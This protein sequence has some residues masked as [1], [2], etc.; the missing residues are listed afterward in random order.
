MGIKQII[1]GLD[2]SQQSIGYSAVVPSGLQ[3]INFFGGDVDQARNLAL[4]GGA[5]NLIG[6]PAVGD[7]ANGALFASHTAYV[8]TPVKLSAQMTIIGV[9]CPNSD[10]RAYAVSSATTDRPI[11]LSI[12]SNPTSTSGVQSLTIQLGG[13]NSST[14]ANTAVSTEI[15]NAIRN[16]TPI[17]FAATIDCSTLSAAKATIKDLKAGKS[18]T[19]TRSLSSINTTGG[20]FLIGSDLDSTTYAG[21]RVLQAAIWN[22]VLTDDE[23]KAQYGQIQSF[24]SNVLGVD[25]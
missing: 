23:I 19:D 5:A 18:A 4:T 21:S 24:Y 6:Q 22:R 9:F 16:N 15:T 20:R 1:K 13:V 3:Y 8:Q 14:G 12:Y 2:G 25:I 17:A 11:G 10:T 7:M